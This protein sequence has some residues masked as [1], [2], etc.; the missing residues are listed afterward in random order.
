MSRQR[1]LCATELTVVT[2][3]ATII[4]VAAAGGIGTCPHRCGAIPYHSALSYSCQVSW[5]WR[6]ASSFQ[7]LTIK[8]GGTDGIA[9][10]DEEKKV[11][12][13]LIML[14]RCYE[15]VL[16]TGVC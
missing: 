12:T 6:G 3:P 8:G 15:N 7:L 13:E 10:F 11:L 2:T 4:A 14:R 1:Y 9:T 16:E 5:A